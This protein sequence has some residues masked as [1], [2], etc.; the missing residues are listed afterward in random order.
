[1]KTKLAAKDNELRSIKSK[2]RD[3]SERGFAIF[4]SPSQSNY[5]IASSRVQSRS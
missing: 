3:G 5:D 4:T 2:S 1:M